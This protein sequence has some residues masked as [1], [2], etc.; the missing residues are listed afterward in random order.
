[1]P[2]MRRRF[3][4]TAGCVLLALSLLILGRSPSVDAAGSSS[5]NW[6][7]LRDGRPVAQAERVVEVLAVGDVMPGRGLADS[8]G[9][10]DHV[11]EVLQNADLA[12]GNLE[13]AV[14]DVVV[15]DPAHSLVL[16]LGTPDAL[17]GAGFDLLSLANNHTLDAGAAGLAET[18]ERLRAA[19]LLPVEVGPALVRQIGGLTFGVLA[20]NDVASADEQSLLDVVRQARQEAD[21]VIVLT[22]WGQEYTRH[23]V[24]A[25]RELAADLLDAGADVILGSHPHVVQD[26]QIDD[27]TQADDH[28]RLVAYSLGNFAFDQGWDDTAQG[29]ALRLLFDEGGLRAVQA[30][31]LWTTPRPRWMD[32]EDS[33]ALVERILQAAREGF[34]CTGELCRGTDVPDDVRSGIFYSGSIDLTGDGI[35]EIVRR[36]GESA[37]VLERGQIV[38]R[39]PAEWRVRDL[40]LGD[41]NDDGRFE[42]LLAVDKPGPSGSVT[43]HPFVVGY[44]GGMYRDLWG[45]SAVHAPLLEVELA[46][47]DEDGVEELV[48]IEASP[49][50][51]ARTLTVWR[52][53]GWGFSLVWR[54]APAKY[55]DLLVLHADGDQ[56][57]R[58]SV[59]TGL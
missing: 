14:A 31:P 40:A 49:D 59:A 54:S 28:A 12:I 42:I 23:P 30:I 3:G 4:R 7:F 46:D 55:H 13:G 18:R 43:S 11:T 22:H 2:R 45:G 21:V 1:M 35:A 41:P 56:P 58:L 17:A 34:V 15:E 5:G 16:P 24:L 6:I 29:L 47:L 37:E 10:F 44:R 48:T 53:H 38:W 8:A 33:T 9:L 32:A 36:Q 26:V 51:A 19:G 39:N 20:W 50:E 52:W 25:Q 27:P 57:T